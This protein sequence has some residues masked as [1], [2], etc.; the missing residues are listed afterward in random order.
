MPELLRTYGEILHRPEDDSFVAL[1]IMLGL[2]LGIVLA[3]VLGALFE[4]IARLWQRARHRRDARENRAP[5]GNGG[6]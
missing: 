3:F 6:R 1:V 2:V 4:G 5:A